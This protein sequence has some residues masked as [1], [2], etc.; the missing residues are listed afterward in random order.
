MQKK[1]QSIRILHCFVKL[2]LSSLMFHKDESKTEHINRKKKKSNL[3]RW[4]ID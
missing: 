3:F 4:H 1:T 2:Q